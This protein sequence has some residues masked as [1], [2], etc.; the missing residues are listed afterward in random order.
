MNYVK[1]IAIMVV[2]L[3]ASDELL[4]G[5]YSIDIAIERK[6]ALLDV[7]SDLRIIMSR[8]DNDNAAQ[9]AVNNCTYDVRQV[10]KNKD[11]KIDV[12]LHPSI[13]LKDSEGALVQIYNKSIIYAYSDD[14]LILQNDDT[15][16]NVIIGPVS[17][18]LSMLVSPSTN[19]PSSL[20][21][22]PIVDRPYQ[23]LLVE[24]PHHL[25]FRILCDIPT[26]GVRVEETSI[27]NF[28]NG[29]KGFSRITTSNA[30]HNVSQ[31][32]DSVIINDAFMQ[33]VGDSLKI[34]V[35]RKGGQPLTKMAQ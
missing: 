18:W 3:H 20:A 15:R 6:T 35:V 32:I 1:W 33:S 27:I 9:F 2:F 16:D 25:V 23:V 24:K 26:E 17:D 5:T 12:D 34:N 28:E 7:D 22:I 10:V 31:S 29:E 19:W 11:V 4:S 14:G 8:T 13:H 30:I 21:G